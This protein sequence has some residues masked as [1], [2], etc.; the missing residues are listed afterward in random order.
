MAHD[1]QMPRAVAEFNA[2]NFQKAAHLLGSVDI[3]HL[4]PRRQTRFR[5]MAQTAQMQPSRLDLLGR[6]LRVGVAFVASG[7]RMFRCSWS[8]M[9]AISSEPSFST[10]FLVSPAIPVSR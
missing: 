1:P 2:G 5:E 7:V 6:G 3:H 9:G 4:D 10:P 8:C